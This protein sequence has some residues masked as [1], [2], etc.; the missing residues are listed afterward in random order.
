M[1]S[2]GFTMKV[3][4]TASQKE[5]DVKIYPGIALE[6]LKRECCKELGED[7]EERF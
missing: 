3:K 1:E 5:F 6:D 2:E 7:T 4:I